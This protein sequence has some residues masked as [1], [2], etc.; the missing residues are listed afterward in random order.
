MFSH[1]LDLVNIALAG[2]YVLACCKATNLSV[3]W[4]HAVCIKE[5]MFPQFWILSTLH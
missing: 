1:I 2:T 4:A 5:H 3:I